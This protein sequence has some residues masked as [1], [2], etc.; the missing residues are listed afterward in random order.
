MDGDNW[1]RHGSCLRLP[2]ELFYD[3][4]KTADRKVPEEAKKA[5]AGCPVK[6]EC[7]IYALEWPELYGYWAGTTA[8]ERRR[9]RAST[10]VQVTV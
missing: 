7:L 9:I 4:E 10:K 3:Y 6:S 8:G 5:C 1:W 2:T